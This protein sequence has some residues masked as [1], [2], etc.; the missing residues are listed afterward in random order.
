M[1][2]KAK[3]DWIS[4]DVIDIGHFH[5]FMSFKKNNNKIQAFFDK[6]FPETESQF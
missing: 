4:T 6:K 1:L 3:L 2:L 5:N